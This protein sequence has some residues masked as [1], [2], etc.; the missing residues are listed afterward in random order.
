MLKMWLSCFNINKIM[1]II[2]IKIK[3]K[4]IHINFSITT[5]QEV[6]IH[7]NKI[8]ISGL[9]PTAIEMEDF[10]KKTFIFIYL[11]AQSLSCGMWDLVP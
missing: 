7:K 9:V 10:F 1:Q 5:V 3:H 8:R 11:A 4:L 2:Y 6:I